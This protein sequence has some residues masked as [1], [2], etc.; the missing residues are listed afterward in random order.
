[1][2]KE[3]EYLFE[4]MFSCVGVNLKDIDVTKN[5]WYLQYEWTRAE[6]IEFRSWL[7]KQFLHNKNLK[8]YLNLPSKPLKYLAEK[9][10][11]FFI[12][13]WGWKTKFN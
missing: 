4:K 2:N 13:N 7:I 3:L 9:N 12:A 8:K 6:E 10:A 11:D 1:M 5:D